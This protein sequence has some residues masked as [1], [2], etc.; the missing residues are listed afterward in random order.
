MKKFYSKLSTLEFD[1]D[2]FVRSSMI[3]SD[4]QINQLVDSGLRLVHKDFHLNGDLDSFLKNFN[5]I[6]FNYLLELMKN[7]LY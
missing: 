6:D 1:C 3:V 7:S 4:K 5:G 2:K